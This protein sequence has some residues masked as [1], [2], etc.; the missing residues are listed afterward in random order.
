[1]T[2]YEAVGATVTRIQAQR[3]VSAHGLSWEDFIADVGDKSEYQGTEVL[4]WVG[5]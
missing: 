2:Y 5:Y 3:E 4:D 1:M